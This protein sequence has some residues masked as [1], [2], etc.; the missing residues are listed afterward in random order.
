V[1]KSSAFRPES[2][3][4]FT[5]FVVVGLI[6]TACNLA[7]RYLFEV[8]ASYEVA[9]A[10]ANIVGLLSAFFLNR[11]FVFKSRAPR[12]M[13]ELARFTLVNLAG[14]VIAWIVAVLLYRQVFPLSTSGTVTNRT[15]PGL[16]TLWISSTSRSRWQRLPDA[17]YVNPN[18]LK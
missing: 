16:N 13:T 7:S 11:W 18:Y 14:I 5:G 3:R 8:A 1:I 2:T 10:G 12:L 6:S 15:P 4:Q 9:L 17:V